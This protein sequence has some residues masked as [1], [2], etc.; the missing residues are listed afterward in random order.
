MHDGQQQLES[1][2]DVYTEEDYGQGE[3]L[4]DDLEYDG[5]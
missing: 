3:F 5:S 2:E 4:R 1:G